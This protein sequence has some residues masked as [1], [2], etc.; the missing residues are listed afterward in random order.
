MEKKNGKSGNSDGGKSMSKPSIERR[1]F[2]KATGLAGAGLMMGL[3]GIR[4][5]FAQPKY[6]ASKAKA[7][8]GDVDYIVIGS[9]INSLV[10]AALLA[11]GGFK[12]AMLERNREFGGCIQTGQVTHPGFKHDLFSSWHPLFITSPAYAELKADLSR[13]GLQYLNTD[14]PTAVVL[15]DNKNLILKRSRKDNVKNFEAI[16]RGDGSAY[17][18]GIAQL[19]A[20][21]ELVFGMLGKELWTYDFAKLLLSKTWSLGVRGVMDFFA[22]ALQSCRAWLEND[23]NSPLVRALLT[24]WVLH[25]GL[26]PD[27]AL[28]G[29]MDKLIFFSLEAAGMPV[30]KGGSHIIVDAFVKLIEENGGICINQVDVDEIVLE[31]K[32][33]RGVK[34]KDGNTYLAKR[35]IICNVTPTQLYG[36]LLRNAKI[37]KKV[38][39]QAKSYRYGRGDMQIHLALSEPPQWP[40]AGLQKVAMVHVT[41]GLNG[42][43]RAV[44]E[45]ECGLLPQTATVVVGQPTALDASRAPKGGWILWLQLQELPK[46]GSIKGDAANKIPTPANGQW[47][48]DVGERYADRIVERLA[49]HIPNLKKS[50]LARKIYTPK[51]LANFNIN[52]VGGDPYSGVC[53]IDQFFFWR[54]LRATKNHTTPIER[55]FHIGAPTHPG[56]GLGGGSGYMV[57]KGLLD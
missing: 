41:P 18:E 25:T 29:F 48:R 5:A 30:V 11:K 14:S 23:F 24:P 50:I 17:Q 9:G 12:V 34:T 8:E 47:T 54:P 51:D 36:R 21:L 33:A 31:G 53:S 10:C 20:N 32:T 44:N 19:E 42:V 15:P 49:R 35:G 57:A 45:A 3:D 39:Q 56:P 37:S 38:R 28:S 13:L 16:A 4:L 1:R 7:L 2:L 43:S 46:D 22:L 6:K 26:G 40:D 27:N 55:L 52:L